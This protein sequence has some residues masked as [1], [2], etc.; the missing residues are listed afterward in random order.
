[1]TWAP[2]PNGRVVCH[3]SCG[4]A[5]AVATKM[6]LETDPDA[7]IVYCDTGAEHPDNERFIKD[8]ES[9]FGKSVRIL[10]STEFSDIWEVF[11]KRRFL[12]DMQAGAPCTAEMKRVPWEKEWR[13]GDVEV[14][15]Y[16]VEEMNRVAQWKQHNNERLIHCP[17]IERGLTKADCFS[18]LK[19]AGIEL[20]MMYKLGFRNNN[21][22]GC[23]KARDF[24]DYWKRVRKFFPEHFNRMAKLE[25][26]FGFALNRVTKKKVRRKV[27]LD[28]I[29]PGD[30]DPR[31]VD[32]SISC[33]A[34]CQLP[35]N[36]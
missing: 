26:E 23:V 33:G 3:F 21:C 5:S 7:E 25:R 28:E 10:K 34:F 31:K 17:L 12:V 2:K 4:A 30:P 27:F 11:E 14:F 24:I 29:E 32:P 13:I 8:C 36:E 20:P 1:M 16:T 15:G 18:I 6:T 35:T 19:F 22:I 9:W